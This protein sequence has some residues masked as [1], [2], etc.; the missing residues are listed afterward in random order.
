MV[1]LAAK[2]ESPQKIT[3]HHYGVCLNVDV[4]TS[5]TLGIPR[6][7]C[8]DNVCMFIKQDALLCSVLNIGR[9]WTGFASGLEGSC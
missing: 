3:P 4:S 5:N 8:D 6:M 9:W 1:S 7:Q 2:K